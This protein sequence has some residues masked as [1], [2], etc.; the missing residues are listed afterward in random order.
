MKQL[1][2]NGSICEGLSSHGFLIGA[3]TTAAAANIPYRVIETLGC[4]SSDTYQQYIRTHSDAV[5]KVLHLLA[6]M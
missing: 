4:W 2:G 1:I 5:A 3:A 6:S